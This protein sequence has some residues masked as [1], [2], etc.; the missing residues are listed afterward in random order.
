MAYRAVVVG[1]SGYTG[2]ELLRLL[3]G[4]PEIEVVHVTADSNAGARVAD[5]YPSLVAAYPDLVFCPLEPADLDGLDVAFLALPHGASQTVAADLVGRV[6]HLVD[7]GADFRLPAADYEQWY[8][9]THQAPELLDRFAFGLV[10]LFRDD[11]K[12]HAHVAN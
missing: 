10:E 7:I 12:G 3:A 2:A 6:A 8:G 9:E 1:G 5:L 11:I 4:H